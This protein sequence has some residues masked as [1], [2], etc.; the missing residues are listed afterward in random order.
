MGNFNH[1]GVGRP[2]CLSKRPFMGYLTIGKIYWIIPLHTAGRLL[3][4]LET[5]AKKH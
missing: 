5:N 2:L 3:R 4:V 1:M